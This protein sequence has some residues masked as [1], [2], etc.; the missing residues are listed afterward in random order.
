MISLEIAP[1]CQ[2]CRRFR[3]VAISQKAMSLGEQ[4]DI[5]ISVKC[6]NSDLCAGLYEHLQREIS[7]R[8]TK[9]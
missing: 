1:Y 9:K 5:R 6:E 2:N 4:E 3:P 8:E 7:E